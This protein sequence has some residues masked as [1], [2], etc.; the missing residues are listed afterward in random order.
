[1][2]ILE[3]INQNQTILIYVILLT[4]IAYLV[5][6]LNFKDY[7]RPQEYFSADIPIERSMPPEVIINIT[8]FQFNPDYVIIP[9]NTIV[10]WINLDRGMDKNYQYRPRVH[11]I[12]DSEHNYFRSSDLF[13]NQ[14]YS[15]T[16]NRPGV[17]YY[18][19]SHYPKMTG[20]IVVVE[21]TLM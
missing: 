12:V 1:M 5:Y 8:N 4:I 16:F 3:F 17:Y 7:S 18:Y 14:S 10:K 2:N 19:C 6:Q 20:T 21:E 9:V 13:V 15:F 11:D